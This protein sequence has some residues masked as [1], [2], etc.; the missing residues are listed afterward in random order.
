[1]V[2]DF[3]VEG[4]G[5][6]CDDKGEAWLYLETCDRYFN[7]EMFIKQVDSALD[8]FE[9]KF[10]QVT[11]IFLFDNAPSHREYPP[12]GLNAASMNVYPGGKQPMRDTV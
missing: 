10:P 4:H 12:N 7:N 5:Y 1:M 6:L 11:G 2:S 3:I 8:I 9:R